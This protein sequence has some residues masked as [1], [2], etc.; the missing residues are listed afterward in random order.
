MRKR[1]RISVLQVW[2]RPP[3]T[4]KRTPPSWT[5]MRGR[6]WVKSPVWGPRSKRRR[7]SEKLAGLPRSSRPLI[8][9]CQGC[10]L[11]AGTGAAMSRHSSR[12]SFNRLLRLAQLR[13]KM[14]S[15]H[16]RSRC[17]VRHQYE[18]LGLLHL[19]HLHKVRATTLS[20]GTPCFRQRRRSS[21]QASVASELPVSAAAAASA[22][23]GTAAATS[24]TATATA[25][26]VSRGIWTAAVQRPSALIGRRP[27]LVGH[28]QIAAGCRGARSRQWRTPS[29][30]AHPRTRLG[31]P[32]RR[33]NAAP[34]ATTTA[35]T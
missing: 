12:V 3:R 4:Q 11:S 18:T 28:R 22:A 17:S 33:A 26:E 16:V 20:A 7:G 25:T 10:L 32:G 8:T 34:A 6:I 30:R 24:A 15:T 29:S 5:T 35:T 31:M 23:A 1:R 9:I 13:S 27:S 14:R 2:Y 19:K 21:V